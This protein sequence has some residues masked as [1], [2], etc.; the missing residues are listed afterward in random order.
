MK[1]YGKV[2]IASAMLLLVAIIVAMGYVIK[3][4]YKYNDYYERVAAAFNAATIVNAETVW[5]SEDKAVVAA[6]DDE[7]MIVHPDQYKKLVYY[8]RMSAV[9]VPFAGGRGEP[10]MTI[11]LC[12]TVD[13]ALYPHA[14]GE[15]VTVRLRDALGTTVM[16]IKGRELMQSLRDACRKAALAV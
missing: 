12:D 15:T 16:R 1:W 5:E 13:F 9:Y 7:V 14:D 8:L 3:A 10:G 4:K 11:R 2:I 6:F